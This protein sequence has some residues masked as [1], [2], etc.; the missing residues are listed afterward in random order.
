MSNPNPHPRVTREEWLT[1]FARKLQP[2]FAS[3]GEWAIPNN[4]R[5]S[6]GWPIAGGA[7]S[8]NGSSRT[9]GQCFMADQSKAEV[10]EIFISPF[11][12]DPI[13]VGATLVHEIVH[14][15]VGAEEKHAGQFKRVA[16]AVGLEGKMTAT[17]AGQDLREELGHLSAS[18]GGYPHASVDAKYK[19]K[20][21]TTRMLKGA[22]EICGYTIRL[23]KQWA[24]KGLPF[25]PNQDHVQ[26]PLEERPRLALD[27]PI[28]DPAKEEDTNVE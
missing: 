8:P 13:E 1:S 12:D 16:Q 7:R 6:C 10:F 2:W 20:P 23:T 5:V 19:L 17:H 24:L 22:C 26:L 11:L 21:Q 9:I 27:G 4:L 3:H 25:C 28:T 18:L 14:A 15:I